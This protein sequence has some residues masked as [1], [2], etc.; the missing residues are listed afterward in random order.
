MT[1]QAV[2]QFIVE[3]PGVNVYDI[4]KALE[5]STSRVRSDLATLESLGLLLSEHP[6]YTSLYPFERAGDWRD[7]LLTPSR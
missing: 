3:R 6:R 4:A 7:L 2:Y 5:C 1:Y